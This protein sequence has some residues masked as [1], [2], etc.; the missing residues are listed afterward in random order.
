MQLRKTG[1]SALSVQGIP[2]K[3][4]V[5]LLVALLVVLTAAFWPESNTEPTTTHTLTTSSTS[6]P[7]SPQ[8]RYRAANQP[9]ETRHSGDLELTQSLP[10]EDEHALTILDDAL[11]AQT[12]PEAVEIVEDEIQLEYK[13]A[14]DQGDT[15][16]TIFD[17]VEIGQTVMY[18]IL[19]AD[20]QLLALDILR[21]GNLLTFRKNPETL[22]LDEMELYIHAGNQVIY[23]RV[24]DQNFE[25]IEVIHEGDWEQEIV[26]GEIYGSFYVSAIRAGLSKAEIHEINKLLGEQIDFNRQIQAGDRFQIVRNS[27]YVND[28]FTGQTSIEA[29][30]LQQRSRA[31]TAFL[32]EDGNYYDS[33]GE[34]L[35]RAF[36]RL[37]H[38]QNF[39]VSSNFNPRRLHP[40]TGRV[41]PHN[42]TDFAMPTGTPVVSI[43]DGVVTRVENHP[44]AGRYLEIQ[45]GSTYKTR[46]LHMHRIDVR[47]G[48]SVQRGQRIGLSG[49]TG[50]VTGPHLHFEL[51]I[52]GRPVNPMTA[53]LPM[54]SSVPR[55]QLAQFNKRVDELVSIM[56][57]AREEQFAMRRDQNQPGT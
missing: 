16:S 5:A 39:R 2:V 18:Q 26:A 9:P 6:H 19:A 20:E 31:Y 23:R 50:R 14:I 55:E 48:D 45:H 53:N 57:V 46:Y 35:T 11:L 34:S 12:E 37:P 40:V 27:Q 56:E 22:E 30:R 21:P 47:R 28:E 52:N 17:Q 29:I 49:A 10:D 13:I 4:L 42:G 25:F 3:H 38:N 15:L 33:N 7:P 8:I 43:G 51:H 36:R 24:D 1:Q 44:F 32:F 41:S 54:A